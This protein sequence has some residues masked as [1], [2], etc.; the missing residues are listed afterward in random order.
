V[1]EILWSSNG[2][3]EKQRSSHSNATRSEN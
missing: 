1:Q 3:E 2:T